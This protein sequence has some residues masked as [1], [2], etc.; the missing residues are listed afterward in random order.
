MVLRGAIRRTRR[1]RTADVLGAVVVF[2]GL[3]G[4]GP[5]VD[6]GGGLTDEATSTVESSSSGPAVSTASSTSSGTGDRVECSPQS[7]GVSH[8]CAVPELVGYD[9][10]VFVRSGTLGGGLMCLGGPAGCGGQ[11]A[12]T[13]WELAEVCLARTTGASES[14]FCGDQTMSLAAY[15][16][17]GTLELSATDVVRSFSFQSTWTFSA[18]PSDCDV[19]SCAEL[20]ACQGEPP[21]ASAEC[22]QGETCSCEVTLEP[23]LVEWANP[24][25]VSADT[26]VTNSF[27]R[28]AGIE[29]RYCVEGD[30]LR[31]WTP[32][33][34]YELT[35]MT[36]EPVDGC[37]LEGGPPDHPPSRCVTV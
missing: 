25:E 35:D 11:L 2:V 4:C 21:E 5:D 8:F 6:G 34:R 29:S 33:Y 24:Y 37:P 26:I 16:E 31:V 36:C 28:I 3:S 20:E 7:V 1:S 18:D 23:G 15:D 9:E 17:Q 14:W 13:S 27:G 22:T 32:E 19:Q 10:R 12:D 30:T